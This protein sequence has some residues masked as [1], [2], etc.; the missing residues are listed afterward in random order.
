MARIEQLEQQYREAVTRLQ[1][2]Q[3]RLGAITDKADPRRGQIKRELEVAETA[4][5]DLKQQ[6]KNENT[7]RHFAGIGSPLHEAC[8]V[9][10]GPDVVAEL[11]ADAVARQAERDSKAAERRAKTLAA[12][13]PPAVPS[14]RATD[15]IAAMPRADDP[16][17]PA[18]RVV[19]SF[20]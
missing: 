4:I 15:A 18:R 11:E 13:S 2:L 1:T 6:V 3:Q 10:F 17:K 9:R 12:A 5:R 7:R 8:L 14:P 16:P 19:K 20:D